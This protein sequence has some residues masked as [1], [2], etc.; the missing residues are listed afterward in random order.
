MAADST[1]SVD[2]VIFGGGAAGL[3]LLDEL[4]RAGYTVLLLE[5]NAL[6]SGQTIVSQGIIH[7]GVKYSLGGLISPAARAIREMPLRWRRCLA[8]EQAPNLKAT[9]IL[10]EFCHIW[11]T[12]SLTSRLAMIGARKSLHVAP[13]P[14]DHDQRPVIFRRCPG[15]VARLDEQV[16]DTESFVTCLFDQHERRIL[17]IDGP[18]GLEIVAPSPGEIETIRLIN[19]D[20]GAP[21]D[22]RPRRVVFTAGSGNSSLRTAAGLSD[23]MTQRRPLHMVVAR[24]NLPTLNGH[25][26]DGAHTRATITTGR[27]YADRLIWQ[28]GG[29]IAEDGVSMD[30][31]ALIRHAID[32]IGSI[33]PDVDLRGVEWMT[34]AVDRAEAMTRTG[35]RPA[36]ARIAVEGTTI[37]GWPTKLALV[38]HLAEQIHRHLPEPSRAA[39]LNPDILRIWPRPDIAVPPWEEEPSWFTD[40]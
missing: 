8:G 25:C 33:L 37:T 36:D 28:V 17:K 23:T 19:P 15:V 35:A 16:I 13:I 10:A 14:L 18:S 22:L 32:E 24:G 2:V 11:Q 27:D 38:P 7:G 12:R 30:R 39:L 34:Y 31:P 5:A 40:D 1:L 3:W 29:Q 4:H 6:G 9:R 21:L 26:V 20:S